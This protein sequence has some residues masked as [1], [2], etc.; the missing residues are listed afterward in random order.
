[1]PP[2]VTL[3]VCQHIRFH[4]K[5][6]TG[7]YAQVMP[8]RE[9]R[10]RLRTYS[11]GEDVGEDTTDTDADA[12]AA[13][14]EPVVLV[15]SPDAVKDQ[16]YFLS[17]LNQQQLQR[18]L[19]PIGHLQKPRV[20]QLAEKFNLPTKNRKDSQGIC[21]LGKL[22]FDEF[23]EHYLG[24]SPGPIK[25]YKTH[26]IIGQHRGLWFHTIGQ[27]KGIG[28]LL[29]P[30]TVHNGPWFV[31]AKDA[32]SNTLYVTNDLQI[33]QQPRRS[34]MV[35]K[36]SWV[37]G[38]PR[39]LLS[40]G[41][42][43]RISN[44]DTGAPVTATASV[45]KNRHEVEDYAMNEMER[46]GEEK[47]SDDHDIADSSSEINKS[48]P[49]MVLKLKLRHSPHFVK[50]WVTVVLRKKTLNPGDGSPIPPTASSY[51]YEGG[52]TPAMESEC[53]TSPTTATTA[54]ATATDSGVQ[55][56]EEVGDHYDRMLRVTLFERDQGIAPGQFAAFYDLDGTCCLGA[57][58]IADVALD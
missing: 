54:T 45:I 18:C 33:V 32:E 44:T 28:Q 31:A 10:D 58:V 46:A 17:N 25:R 52:G 40:S 4:S 13:T 36:T 30:R 26:E 21:F 34:F 2:Y 41:D 14:T 49:G 53:S 55:C 42:S 38:V 56:A 51:A 5:I 29:A 9:Y 7:H 19:F 23:I 15:Q 16:S 43:S 20:R 12:D 1:M 11:A 50:G 35:H 8:L 48:S 57:G 39:D 3:C 37:A 47:R 24:E 27:R 22:K 6:A